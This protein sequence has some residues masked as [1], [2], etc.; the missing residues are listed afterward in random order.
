MPLTSS[1]KDRDFNL[2][3]EMYEKLK[4]VSGY[5]CNG[6]F[7]IGEDGFLNQMNDQHLKATWKILSFCD[8]VSSTQIL[9]MFLGRRT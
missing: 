8:E 7:S 1:F 2:G 3:N 4:A 6:L 9:F 5:V